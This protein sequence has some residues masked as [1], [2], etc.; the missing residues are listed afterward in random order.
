MDIERTER[1]EYEKNVNS[2][3]DHLVEQRMK[4][5]REKMEAG[6]DSMLEQMK[7]NLKEPPVDIS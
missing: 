4:E 2:M 7:K 6:F 1:A 5:F 3:L